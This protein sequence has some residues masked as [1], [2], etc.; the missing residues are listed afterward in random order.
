MTS[1]TGWIR[2]EPLPRT[3]DLEVALEARIADPMWLLARQWQI[4]EFAGEDAGSPIVA[5]LQADVGRISRFHAGIPPA[6]DGV[7][8]SIDYIDSAT[9]LEVLVE[10]EN[11]RGQRA[12]NQSMGVEAGLHFG[13]LLDVAGLAN[14]RAAY[15]AHYPVDDTASTNGFDPDGAA[16]ANLT[17][18]RVIDGAA[19]HADLLAHRGSDPELT[20]LPA[21]PAVTVTVELLDAVNTWM[22]WWA[23]FVNEPGEAPPSWKSNRL[24]YG[25]AVSAEMSPPQ[26]PIEHPHVVLHADEYHEGDLDWYSFRAET[27]PQLGQP[28]EPAPPRTITRTVIPTPVGYS[29]QPANRFWGFEDAKVSFGGLNSSAGDVGRFLLAEFALL[30]GDDW[31][32]I[33]VDLPVG[34]VSVIRSL[35]I[36]DTFGIVTDVPSSTDLD[37]RWRLFSVAQGEPA[38]V[39]NTFFLPPTLVSPVNGDPVEQVA[40]FRDEMANMVW[41]VERRI[42]GDSGA[43]I[44]RYEEHQQRLGSLPRQTIDGDQVDAEVIYRLSSE[45]PDHWIPFLPVPV[46][47]STSPSPGI[48]LDRRTIVR[49]ESDGPRTI[50]PRGQILEPGTKLTLEEEEVPR[51]GVSVERAMQMTRWFDGSRQVWMGRRK[52]TGRGEG[53]SGL[54]F[55]FTEPL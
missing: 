38:Y 24:E 16:T 42:Q 12:A 47:D 44:D 6:D 54:H 28:A 13:R 9:P 46:E 17:K 35:T 22:E 39:A 53:S 34:S 5:Q 3:R 11:I 19:L 14:L 20:S 7:S 45:V 27:L 4:G 40:L 21:E 23:G 2:L 55:D 31:F 48:Q 49:F 1:I 26:A 37:P 41:G 25:F 32:V 51:A 10:R 30:Y 18:G 52:K 36:T 29:G 33:P 43:V 15:R 50:E 8:G